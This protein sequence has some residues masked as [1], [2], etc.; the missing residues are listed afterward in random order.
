GWITEPQRAGPYWK[1]RRGSN[2]I[3]SALRPGRIVRPMRGPVLIAGAGA[4]GSVVGGLLAAAGS[5][6]TLLGRRAHMDAVRARGLAI[7]GLFGTHRV[8]GLECAT[9]AEDLRGPFGAIFLT[10]KAYD[11]AG[12]VDAVL[13]L[14]ARDR[15]LVCMQN[16]LATP[17]P[18]PA[19]AAPAP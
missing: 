1:V 2:T 4:V 10:G 8:R 14:P 15:V 13:P 16:A 3:L 17:A 7:D 9:A 12:P 6:V 5:T 19:T 18:P 11:A